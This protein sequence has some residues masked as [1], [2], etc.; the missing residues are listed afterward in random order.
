MKAYTSSF[1]RAHFGSVMDEMEKGGV[2]IERRSRK[3]AVLLPIDEY[4]KLKAKA[5]EPGPRKQEAL[6]RMRKWVETP[7]SP[8]LKGLANDPRATAILSKQGKHYA[9]K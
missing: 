8:K 9:Q 1:F 5:A 4:E 6:G 3:P 7:P 2:L